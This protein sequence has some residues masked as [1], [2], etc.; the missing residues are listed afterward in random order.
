MV[1]DVKNIIYLKNYEPFLGVVVGA[2]T[3]QLRKGMCLTRKY[4]YPPLEAFFG[5]NLPNCLEILV[6]PL[7]FL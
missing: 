4:P 5:L 6:K 7:T 2:M 3:V 1:W